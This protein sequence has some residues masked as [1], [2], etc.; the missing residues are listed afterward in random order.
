[1]GDKTQL[2]TIALA[3]KY[4]SIIPVWIGTTT[5]MIIADAIGIIIGVVLGKKIPERFVKWFAATI[6]IAFGLIG[7]YRVFA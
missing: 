5:G 4:T 7:L 2:A 1:M 6:F 3:A